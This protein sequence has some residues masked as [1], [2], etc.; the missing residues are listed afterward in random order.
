MKAASP[1]RGSA[2]S[3]EVTAILRTASLHEPPLLPPTV[4]QIDHYSYGEKG[5]RE[6][7]NCYEWNGGVDSIGSGP[8]YERRIHAGSNAQVYFIAFNDRHATR[9]TATRLSDRSV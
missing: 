7:C 4:R 1:L 2:D 3:R 8:L 9:R 6:L 5:R